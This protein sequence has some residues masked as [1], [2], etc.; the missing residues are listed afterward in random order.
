MMTTDTMSYTKIYNSTPEDNQHV[1]KKKQNRRTM[2]NI[3]EDLVK[4][5][6]NTILVCCSKFLVEKGT[7]FVPQY[8]NKSKNNWVPQTQHLC[9]RERCINNKGL[10]HHTPHGHSC[11]AVPLEH[12]W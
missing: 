5:L 7:K 3:H 12:D 6:L 11:L 2:R 8:V 9:I 10:E 4:I 1:T